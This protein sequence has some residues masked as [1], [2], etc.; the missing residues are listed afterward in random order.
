MNLI[1]LADRVLI[2][3]DTAP[4]V[5]ASGIELVEHN[6]VEQTGVV[7]SSGCGRHP[8]KDEAF[9][10]ARILETR[11]RVMNRSLVDEPLE[12]PELD[13]AQMLRDLT[14]REP[15]LAVGDRV[16]F[17]PFVGQEVR[18]NEE[19]YLVMREADVLAVLEG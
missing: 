1:P 15:E 5:T 7:V 14:G 16:V 12:T 4:T 18:I 6:Q 17:S 9:S 11:S 8:L 2:Q 3:P 13:A 10:L 19:R